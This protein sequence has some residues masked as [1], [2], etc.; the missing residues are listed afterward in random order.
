[1]AGLGEPQ[2]TADAGLMAEARRFP[3]PGQID[4]TEACFIVRDRN[5]HAL[6]YLYFE[7]EPV[8]VLRPTKDKA[9]PL[10]PG[11][12]PSSYTLMCSHHA[13][14]EHCQCEL[15]C[16]TK[17]ASLPSTTT[18][19]YQLALSGA[20]GEGPGSG[21]FAGGGVLHHGRP[22]TKPRGPQLSTACVRGGSRRVIARAIA[23]PP[24]SPSCQILL[25]P[26]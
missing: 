1:M 22:G 9:Q 26:G 20:A 13:F 11:N 18:E 14:G 7:E 10:W 5:G 16:M 4:E 17:R 8:A 24:T 19:G 2:A 3:P 25:P 23:S 12:V 6:A 15:S 21:G